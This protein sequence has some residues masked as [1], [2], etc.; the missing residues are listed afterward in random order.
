VGDSYQALVDILQRLTRLWLRDDT[1][2]QA[3]LKPPDDAR[4]AHDRALHE[5]ASR[6]VQ[7]AAREA[8]FQA[9][10][11]R[12]RQ[13]YGRGQP[14]NDGRDLCNLQVDEGAARQ[15]WAAALRIA[16][17]PRLDATADSRSTCAALE[18]DLL[19]RLNG[20]QRL[21]YRSVLRS[22][23]RYAHTEVDRDGPVWLAWLLERDIV[24][25]LGRRLQ[26]GGLAAQADE[27]TSLSY[28]E[29]LDW[30]EGRMPREM[31]THTLQVRRQLLRRWARYT[32]PPILGEQHLQPL[33]ALRLPTE[34]DA[35]WRGLGVSAGTAQGRAR[36]ITSLGQAVNILPGEVLV[37]R[38]P[39]FE[40]TPWFG[41]AAAVVAEGGWLLDDAA[42]LAREYGVPAVFRVP[43]VTQRLHDGDQLQVDATRGV[44][45][46][47]T[48]E[49]DWEAL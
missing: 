45:A 22:V 23:R 25:E 30:L 21:V 44:V 41:V 33:P 2:Y 39:L 1:P 8:A 19:K 14:W 28:Q 4:Q 48:P 18:L 26:I 10:L 17:G 34:A 27:A 35:T 38:A 36:V 29:V 20:L 49:P 7:A 42:V 6:N 37:L 3:L 40:L 5:Q 47:N 24:H 9:F 43:E 12:F 13:I 16:T 32:P 31:L 11:R 46:R 15:A